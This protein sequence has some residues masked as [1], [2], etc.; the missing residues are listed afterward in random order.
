MANVL[1]HKKFL[2]DS[3][4]VLLCMPDEYVAS[5]LGAYLNVLDKVCYTDCNKID[6][7]VQLFDVV[8][9]ALTE[10]VILCLDHLNELT[11][12]PFWERVA[13]PVKFMLELEDYHHPKCG[14]L[15]FPKIRLVIPHT[16]ADL[17]NDDVPENLVL[18]ASRNALMSRL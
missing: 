13:Q 17:E 5:D 18:F 11:L 9:K 8:N 2:K 14:L 6:S 10:N 1:F 16:D 3:G 4:I 7:E 12:K 15:P